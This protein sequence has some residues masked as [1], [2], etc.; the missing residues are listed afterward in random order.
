VRVPSDD[1]VFPA[2]EFSVRR[3]LVPFDEDS[4]TFSMRLFLLLPLFVRVESEKRSSIIF[5]MLINLQMF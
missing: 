2:S 3:R 1:E 5:F 4:E